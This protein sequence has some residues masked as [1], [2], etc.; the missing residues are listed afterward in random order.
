MQ[1]REGY[2]SDDKRVC[3]LY[4]AIYG[5]KQASRAW[6]EKLK[7]T[8]LNLGCIQ[9]KSDNSLYMKRSR[10]GTIFILVYVDDM[11]ITGDNDQEISKVIQLLDQ[12]FSIKNLGS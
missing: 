9:V 4:K 3:R 6:Y 2:N 1:E 11:L 12:H 7:M 5:L 10:Q 8:L